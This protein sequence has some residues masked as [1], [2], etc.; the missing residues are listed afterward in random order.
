[1][2]NLCVRSTGVS[3]CTG[4]VIAKCEDEVDV[5][6]KIEL[7][8]CRPGPVETL[9]ARGVDFPDARRGRRELSL[10]GVRRDLEHRT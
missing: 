9:T 8:N 6:W 1:M 10:R 7:E 2:D 5:R 4:S 3:S